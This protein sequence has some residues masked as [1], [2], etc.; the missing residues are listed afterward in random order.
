MGENKMYNSKR[1]LIKLVI[2]L[3]L[4]SLIIGCSKVDTKLNQSL[5]SKSEYTP[6]AATSSP[7][8]E[9]SLY[10]AGNEASPA[11]ESWIGVYTFSESAP[12]NISRLYSCS[13]YKEND[14][15]Y[16]KIYII[17]FQTM[18]SL[19]AKVS[20]DENSIKLIFYDYLPDNRWASYTKGDILLSFEKRNAQLYTSWGKIHPILK[21][22]TKSG[23]VYF[24]VES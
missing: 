3:S 21:S 1:L 24:K 22:N 12:P 14:N 16:A 18:Q 4:C 2:F 20:G 11:L 17:G 10:N 13:I 9:K 6:I 5:S 23:E 8:N 19:Q 15:Y 7:T